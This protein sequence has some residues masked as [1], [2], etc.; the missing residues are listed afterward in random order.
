[1]YKLSAALALTGLVGLAFTSGHDSRPM[2][3]RDTQLAIALS[4]SAP[5]NAEHVRHLHAR[6][7]SET[8]FQEE[9]QPRQLQ[10]DP[11][12]QTASNID[13]APTG[14]I[15]HPRKKPKSIARKPQR[16]M[17]NQ[18]AISQPAPTD[19]TQSQKPRNFFEALFNSE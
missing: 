9:T 12:L 18:E 10:A 16:E 3:V 7:K 8:A 4:S 11:R 13:S 19:E 17:T 15:K 5:G 2:A 6:K 14:E 1:M